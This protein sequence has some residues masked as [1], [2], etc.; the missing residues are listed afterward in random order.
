MNRSPRLLVAVAVLAAAPVA[1]HAAPAPSILQ[2]GKTLQA[3]ATSGDVHTDRAGGVDAVWG[4]HDSRLG[5]L[6][7]ARRAKGR[8]TFGKAVTLNRPHGVD[9][10]SAAHIYEHAGELRILFN[11]SE[12]SIPNEWVARSKNHGKSWRLQPL[13]GIAGGVFTSSPTSYGFFNRDL[14]FISGDGTI[15][16][17]FGNNGAESLYTINAALTSGTMLSPFITFGTAAENFWREANGAIWVT[18]RGDGGVAYRLPNGTNGVAP[19]GKA[20]LNQSNIATAD[21]LAVAHGR[22]VIV[23]N[24]CGRLL[25]RSVTAAGK[26]SA[27]RRLG[28]TNGGLR[29]TSATY[30]GGRYRIAWAGA[31][32]DIREAS[33]AD[34]T[35]WKVAKGVI[36]AAAGEPSQTAGVYLDTHKGSWVTWGAARAGAAPREQYGAASSA[37]LVRVPKVSAR[38]IPHAKKGHVGTLALAGPGRISLK[39]TVKGRAVAIRLRDSASDTVTLSVTVQVG[40]TIFGF[41]NSATVH[42][43]PG[44]AKVA[45]LKPDARN[46]FTYFRKGQKVGFD[47]V[48]RNGELTIGGAKIVG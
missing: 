29:S 43:R 2:S 1:A 25:T 42:L 36:P 32:G 17:A 19:F 5:H 7:F 13:P 48:G 47:I 10:M 30:A 23:A 15:R 11:A 9:G 44:R 22:A 45:H 39:A 33:S 38:G 40:N 37:S 16:G 34:G 21:S 14:L 27:A 20:C 26:L 3:D 31:D 6:R 46:A 4:V 18:G 35:S 8:K 28:T 24:Y 12:N 41:G